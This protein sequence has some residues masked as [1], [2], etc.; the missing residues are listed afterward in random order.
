MAQRA[1]AG[2]DN[3]TE[4]IKPGTRAGRRTYSWAK[5]DLVSGRRLAHFQITKEEA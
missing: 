5:A 3:L 4:K 2:T 1:A